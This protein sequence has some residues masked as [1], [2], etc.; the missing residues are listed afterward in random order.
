MKKKGSLLIVKYI[1]IE[2]KKK[3]GGGIIRLNGF[4]HIG[5][6]YQHC[7]L[8]NSGLTT[9]LKR[10]RKDLIREEPMKCVPISRKSTLK[11]SLFMPRRQRSVNEAEGIRKRSVDMIS[12]PIHLM[13]HSQIYTARVSFDSTIEIVKLPDVG[14]R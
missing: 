13:D 6:A 7:I 9:W 10:P 8:A 11:R 12:S 4:V 3:R 14:I 2:K 5:A 1:S